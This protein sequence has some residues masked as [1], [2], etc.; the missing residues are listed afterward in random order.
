MP[1]SYSL[2]YGFTSIIL[3]ASNLKLGFASVTN[4]S[5]YIQTTELDRGSDDESSK[6]SDRLVSQLLLISFW[7]GLL[8]SC[9][10]DIFFVS[11][12]RDATGGFREINLSD[13]MNLL[14]SHTVNLMYISKLRLNLNCVDGTF[15]VFA[16]YQI[17]NPKTSRWPYNIR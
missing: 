7:P 1:L 14:S 2:S 4:D 3:D 6:W 16:S 11:D 17:G 10:G 13:G 8:K 12:A 9:H 15:L 5:P